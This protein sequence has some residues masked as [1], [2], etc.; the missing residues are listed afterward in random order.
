MNASTRCRAADSR[1]TCSAVAGA[2][3]LAICLLACACSRSPEAA[4][5]TTANTAPAAASAT[6]EPVPESAAPLQNATPS[7]APAT[8]PGGK[9]ELGE[10]PR[11]PPESE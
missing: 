1:R 9:I 6:T 8:G 11:L 2:G 10:P 4:A 5:P 3:L 7:R